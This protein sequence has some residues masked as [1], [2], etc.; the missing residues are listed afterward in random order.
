MRRFLALVLLAVGFALVGA[1]AA[2]AHDVLEST[3]PADR[4]TVDRLPQAVTLTFS[5]DPL[6]LGTQILVKGPSGNVAHGDPTIEGRVVHQQLSA[7]A[8]AG[9]Y[10]V[11]Y[12][13]TSSDGHPISGTFSFHATVGLD[14]STATQGAP[15]PAQQPGSPDVAAAQQSSFVPVMLTIAG[16]VIVLLIGAVVWIGSRRRDAAAT[17]GTADTPDTADTKNRG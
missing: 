13:V 2:S 3:S 8:P 9:D 12:R 14:G 7:Q 11:T 1:P 16:V 5:D 6:A 10:V 15:V 4:T 17:P